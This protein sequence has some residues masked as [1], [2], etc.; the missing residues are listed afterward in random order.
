LAR[1]LVISALAVP[2]IPCVPFV[3]FAFVLS[4]PLPF[5]GA[6]RW[7]NEFILVDYA[8]T[9]SFIA[10]NL[11]AVNLER[12]VQGDLIRLARHDSG[13]ALVLRHVGQFFLKKKIANGI[14]NA[15]TFAPRWFGLKFVCAP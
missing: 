3:P 1:F 6:H 12:R 9:I 10:W 5:Y 13:I 8:C 15:L 4:V 2:S 7:T 14:D 11:G